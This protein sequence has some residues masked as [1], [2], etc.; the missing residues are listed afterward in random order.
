MLSIASVAVGALAHLELGFWQTV[1]GGPFQ[2]GRSPALVLGNICSG[3]EG[4]RQ[5]E[6]RSSVATFDP[7]RQVEDFVVAEQLELQRQSEVGGHQPSISASRFKSPLAH[8][9]NGFFVKSQS[10]FFRYDNIARPPVDADD[11]GS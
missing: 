5:L 9:R 7:L 4:V 3:K 10:Q 1:P 11:Q 6:F 8:R 2:Q